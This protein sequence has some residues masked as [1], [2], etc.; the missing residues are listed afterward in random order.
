MESH[1]SCLPHRC[2]QG[3]SFNVPEPGISRQLVLVT[4]VWESGG[5]DEKVRYLF[6]WLIFSH[7][8]T[9]SPGSVLDFLRAPVPPHCDDQTLLYI[10][11]RSWEESFLLSPGIRKPL[12]VLERAQW[13]TLPLPQRQIVCEAFPGPC[14]YLL[15]QVFHANPNLTGQH[16]ERRLEKNLEVYIRPGW[17]RSSFQGTLHPWIG[18]GISPDIPP[19]MV[20]VWLLSPGGAASPYIPD[21]VAALATSA[22]FWFNKIFNFIVPCVFLCFCCFL[23]CMV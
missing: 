22:L 5:E 6:F 2:L 17:V 20:P 9:L 4:G 7:R 14:G 1:S 8:Q 3:G 12:W 23:P 19:W 18:R 21:Y 16:L 11:G 15:P 13:C 10:F